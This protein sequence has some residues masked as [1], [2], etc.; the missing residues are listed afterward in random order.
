MAR[1]GATAAPREHRRGNA[2]GSG[3]GYDWRVKSWAG[4]PLVKAV[5]GIRSRSRASLSFEELVGSR[6]RIPQ[7][8]RSRHTRAQWLAAGC[9]KGKLKGMKVL[10]TRRTQEKDADLE[11]GIKRRGIAKI[12]WG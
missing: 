5:A 2:V 8:R 11:V 4:W 6:R 1:A 9:A 7:S 10:G 12:L 3:R